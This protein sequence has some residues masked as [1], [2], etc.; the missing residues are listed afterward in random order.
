MHSHKE[1]FQ[2]KKTLYFTC[3]QYDM[4][5]SLLVFA[6]SLTPEMPNSNNAMLPFFTKHQHAHNYQLIRVINGNTD[7]LSVSN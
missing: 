5:Q 2:W 3:R 4:P 6:V 7:C 1:S